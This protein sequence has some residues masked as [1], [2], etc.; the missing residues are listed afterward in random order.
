V[1]AQ[2][3]KNMDPELLGHFGC[4]ALL[5]AGSMPKLSP[6]WTLKP[7]RNRTRKWR[8]NFI[9]IIEFLSL[10]VCASV[11]VLAVH[12][13]VVPGIASLCH[14]LAFSEKTEGQIIGYATSLPEFVV[15]ISSAMSGVKE[16][17][18]WNIASSNMINWVLFL[19]A[20]GIFRQWQ[21][22]RRLAFL[23]ELTFGL[24]SVAVPLFLLGIRIDPTIPICLGLIGF[25]VTYKILDARFFH[26]AELRI[27]ELDSVSARDSGRAIGSIAIGIFMVLIAGHFLGKSA[28][29][30][31]LK[32]SIPSWMVGWILG[33]ITSIPELTSFI[34]I[35]GF[36]KKRDT[37]YLLK[38]TQEA[39]DALVASNMSN[40]GIILPIGM[41]LFLWMT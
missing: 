36:H 32:L 22:L 33:S 12:F 41:M 5:L 21:D 25:F 1:H 3:S 34:E 10:C 4:Q 40:L 30:L 8:Y 15:V 9:V 23:D 35:Y 19:L 11:T 2:P 28:E 18:F 16:A 26:C 14:Q 7:N 31:I 17:G 29:T 37:L 20:V 13:L 24:L 6:A 38:D 27:E 39:L